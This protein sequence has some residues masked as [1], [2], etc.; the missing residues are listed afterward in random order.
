[1]RALSGIALALLLMSIARAPVQARDNWPTPP[2][3]PNPAVQVSGPLTGGSADHTKFE[4]LQKPFA[5]GPEVTKACLSC[6]T[7]TG[8][9]FMKNVHWTWDY[10]DP[11]TGQQLGKKHLINNFCTN[12]RGNEGMCAQCHAGYGWKDETFDFTNQDNIDCPGLP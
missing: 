1:M 6:H 9:H 10:K 4:V 11:E 2:A 12:A 5:S 3:T 8:K 7:E